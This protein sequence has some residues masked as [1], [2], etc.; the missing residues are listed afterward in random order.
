MEQVKAADLYSESSPKVLAERHEAYSAEL[1]KSIS[2]FTADPTVVSKA[3]A[4][5]PVTFGLSL[6]HI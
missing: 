5:L 1:T 2:N 6:I 3:A 4:G